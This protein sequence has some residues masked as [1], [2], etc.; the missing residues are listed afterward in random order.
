[1]PPSGSS[2]DSPQAIDRGQLALNLVLEPQEWIHR[3][4]ETVAFLPNGETRRRLSWD[5]TVPPDGEIAVSAHRIAVPLT[6][7]RKQRLMRLDVYD[8]TG[9]S[10]PV[11]GQ[12]D[13]GALAQAALEAG[14][15][16]A[17]DGDITGDQSEIIRSVV[18]AVS[19]MSVQQKV[20]SLFTNLPA[21]TSEEVDDLRTVLRA[22][23]ESL[24]DS[25][26]FVVEM[27]LETVGR[28]S[29]VKM[30]YD[31][32]LGGRAIPHAT[33]RYVATVA[34]TGWAGAKSW[35]LEVHAPNGLMVENLRYEAWD[36]E[37]FGVI[38]RGS[39]ESTGATAHISGTGLSSD[40]ES[41]ARLVLAPD[42][43]GLVN[44]TLTAALF[45]W[46]LLMVMCL[47]AGPLSTVTAEADRAGAVAGVTLAIPAV[48][49]AWMARGPEHELVSRLLILPRIVTALTALVL[50]VAATALVLGLDEQQLQGTLF[51]LYVAQGWVL[52]WATFIRLPVGGAG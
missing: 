44:Q 47:S 48:V 39:S 10:L 23:A 1:M 29:L 9:S 3:R 16:I 36:P 2:P 34:G 40:A 51:G 49:V 38:S 41:E 50:L 30:N 8:Q 18:H 33:G 20:D 28:R 32:A 21:A 25:F 4:V 35:H 45:S 11:W 27:P 31:G 17:Q 15:K 24:A 7:L 12:A 5:F 19:L 43:A 46:V 6:L 52:F 37:G 14:L 42:P 26:I 22:L 13:N